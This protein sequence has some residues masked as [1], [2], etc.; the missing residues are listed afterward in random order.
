MNQKLTERNFTL[1]SR[2][3]LLLSISYLLEFAFNGYVRSLD[4]G[5]LTRA[6]QNLVSIAPYLMTLLLNILTAI[7]VYKDKVSQKIWT[8]YVIL[9]AI[10]YRPIGV[11]AFLLYSIYDNRT[12]HESDLN[13]K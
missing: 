13:Q 8:K 2:C 6:N 7:I 3:A 1:I 5:L 4:M 12:G 9:A 10:L 11:V